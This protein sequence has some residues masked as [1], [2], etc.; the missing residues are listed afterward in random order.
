MQTSTALVASGFGQPLAH[1]RRV[2]GRALAGAAL[3][4]SVALAV[5]FGGHQVASQHSLLTADT[6]PQSSIGGPGL[7]SIGG[8]GLV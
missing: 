4:V 3:F 2:T 8:P 1:A 7:V 6:T 5:A